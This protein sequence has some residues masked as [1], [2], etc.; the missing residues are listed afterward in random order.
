MENLIYEL[1]KLKIKYG[2]SEADRHELKKKNSELEGKNL[3]LEGKNSELED[4]NLKLE[5]KNS[6]L[7]KL[8]AY[9]EECFRLNRHRQFG[10][11]KVPPKVKTR[12]F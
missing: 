12:I 9:Y 6:E 8:V 2:K 1:E 5:N 10:Q 11:S 7:V 3:K 4:M